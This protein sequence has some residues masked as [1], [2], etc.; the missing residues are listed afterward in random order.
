MPREMWQML[1]SRKMVK[2]AWEVVQT[3]CLSADRVKDINT[4]K[5]LKDFKNIQFKEG[6]T[7]D[8][9]GMHI[10][11]LIA[12]LKALGETVEDTCVVKKFL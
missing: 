9:F 6:E 5:L 3:M 2:E 7:I 8:D 10:T 1:G 11:N 12:N 4:Q